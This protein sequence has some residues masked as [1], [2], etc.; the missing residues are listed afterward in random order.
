[1][2]GSWRTNWWDQDLS[3]WPGPDELYE[4][5]VGDI[6]YHKGMKSSGP[7]GKVM[8]LF[9]NELGTMVA[10]VALASS[11]SNQIITYRVE[12]LLPYSAE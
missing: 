7:I 1:M 4:I 8:A 10:D 6:V 11:P 2:T 5:K 3:S 9:P 12:R